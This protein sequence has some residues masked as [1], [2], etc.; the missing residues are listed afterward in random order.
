MMETQLVF[1]IVKKDGEELEQV[2][3]CPPEHA[4]SIVNQMLAQYAQVGMMRKSGNKFLLL[5]CG[6]IA[7]VEVELPSVVIASA[8]EAEKA[9]KA[10]GNLIQ[11]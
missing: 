3:N 5:C 7:Y 10:H 2:I 9:S 6:E 8:D 11:M 4:E 1:K